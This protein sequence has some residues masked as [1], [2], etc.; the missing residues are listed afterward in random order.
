MTYALDHIRDLEDT[1][2][3]LSITVT[4][5]T[6]QLNSLTTELNRMANELNGLTDLDVEENPSSARLQAGENVN[7]AVAALKNV[8]NAMND[9]ITNMHQYLETTIGDVNSKLDQIKLFVTKNLTSIVYRPEVGKSDDMAY[10]YGFPVIRAL[11]LEPQ[12]YFEF[13]W[14][15][16]VYKATPSND[17]KSKQ[18][19]IIAKYWL[20]PSSTDITKYD[21]Q[22]D[23]VAG[24]NYISRGNEDTDKA[25]VTANVIG[26]D[27]GGILSV[28]LILDKGENVNNANTK[29][30]ALE[31][32]ACYAWITTVALQAVRNDVDLKECTD[33]VTSDYAIIV[34]DYMNNLLLAYNKF[35]DKD[36]VEGNDMFHLRTDYQALLGENDRGVFSDSL[37][38][39]ANEV[40][41]L[42]KID[43]HYDGDAFIMSHEEAEKRGF[44]FDYKLLTNGDENGYFELNKE[45]QTISIKEDKKDINSVGKVCNVRVMLKEKGKTDGK[46]YTYGYISIIIT[47]V[48]KT[49]PV[50]VPNLVL[51]CTDGAD[52]DF[53][54]SITWAEL[55][56]KIIEVVGESFS[57]DNY[58]IDL[59]A[60]MTKVDENGQELTTD[61]KASTL[62]KE[63]LD[64]KDALVWGFSEDLVKKLFYNDDNTAKYA[65]DET[66]KSDQK[67]TV[68]V[69]LEPKD[70]RPDVA[71]VSLKIELQGLVYP[72]AKFTM[73]Q[74][75]ER[76]WFKHWTDD[77]AIDK[78]DRQEV[79][80]NV[81][82]VGQMQ[83]INVTA[84]ADDDFYFDASSFFVKNEFK[85]VP[86]SPF[87]WASTINNEAPLYFDSEAYDVV[88]TIGSVISSPKEIVTGASGAKYALYLTDI[89]SL[90]LMATKAVDG[91]YKTSADDQVVVELSNGEKVAPNKPGLKFHEYVKFMGK[92]D[93]T[94]S[95][96][97]DL[98]NYAAHY[99]LGDEATKDPQTFTTHM[100]FADNNELSC[101]PIALS[102][103]RNFDIRYLRP[104]SASKKLPK[105]IEDAVDGGSD[106]TKIYLTDIASFEDWR[107]I[108]FTAEN[109][110][111]YLY[112]YGVKKIVADFDNARTNLNG[113][114]NLAYDAATNTAKE[115]TAADEAAAKNWPLITDVTSKLKFTPDEAAKKPASELSRTDDYYTFKF[116]NCGY[117]EY[118]NNAGNV[119]TF[120][121]YL[122]ISIVYDWGETKQEYVLVT[123][124]RTKGQDI[125][126][127]ARLN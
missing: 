95:Y 37:E 91:A 108:K 50:P 82:V 33:T 56:Q 19:D 14:D 65:Y 38:Y 110:M 62:K 127:R 100:I 24:K 5:I 71:D 74:R 115:M 121:I 51:Q 78:A 99:E 40:V 118:Q 81:D 73:D 11:L 9:K 8:L 28:A 15:G 6:T 68:Y 10:L 27:K 35:A 111:D 31:S 76:Y 54:T 103:D 116:T 93:E 89:F 17:K 61:I 124:T 88:P 7:G 117:Y 16:D 21:W 32:N 46:S 112:Y 58:T 49:V 42:T 113:G 75:I 77:I 57:F 70:G 69:N 53:T 39:N 47:N 80:A 18:F 34:P 45:N 125:T 119:G 67:F 30:I 85:F 48:K 1:Q 102:G 101:L 20:N 107:K 86:T 25:G 44:E 83:T 120:Q 59:G 94:Y 29:S 2:N 43:I 96:A 109:H 26:V 66:G 4:N 87:N 64:N 72:T 122:P 36:H 3:N 84:K 13:A 123:I 55:E 114:A 98:L 41:D 60:Y 106:A 79:H 126:G 90:K 104:L 97:R 52:N 63:T 105:I 12:S 22:F 92:R 23:E